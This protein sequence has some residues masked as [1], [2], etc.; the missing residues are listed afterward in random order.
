MMRKKAAFN[1]QSGAGRW[2]PLN[3][4]ILKMIKRIKLL[5][6]TGIFSAV[7]LVGFFG[8][9]MPIRG[10]WK[11]TQNEIVQVKSKIQ[12]TD[13]IIRESKDFDQVLSRRHE[14]LA[15]LREGILEPGRQAQVIA[16]LTQ[17][18]QE[19][20]V[21]ISSIRPVPNEEKPGAEKENQGI[22]PLRFQL[23]MSGNYKA[24]GVFFETLEFSPLILNILE[25]SA[26]PGAN[27]E[28]LEIGMELAAYEGKP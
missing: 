5:E 26:K 8:A 24:L 17:A 16:L 10:Q 11:K 12:R 1:F 21:T 2:C 20:G 27:M 18:T 23:E 22:K 14:E 28:L 25:F 6:W 9:V 7:A 19:A 13:E 15:K 4:E 3:P